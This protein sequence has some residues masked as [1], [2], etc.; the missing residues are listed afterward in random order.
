MIR[1][2]IEDIIRQMNQGEIEAEDAI[3][4]LCYLLE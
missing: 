3:D 4:Q 1:E 2:E